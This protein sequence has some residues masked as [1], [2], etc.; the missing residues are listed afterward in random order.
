MDIDEVACVL[1]Q[2]RKVAKMHHDSRRSVK[3]WFRGQCEILT[4]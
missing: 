1:L 3:M 2:E 4:L